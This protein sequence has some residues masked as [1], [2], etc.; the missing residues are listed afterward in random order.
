MLFCQFHDVASGVGVARMN[1]ETVAWLSGVIADMTAM[2]HELRK[3]VFAINEGEGQLLINTL[4]WARNEWVALPDGKEIYAEIPADGVCPAD[5][6]LPQPE[7]ASA[8]VQDGLIHLENRYLQL[9]IDQG[10]AIVSLV[11]KENSA[12]LIAPGQ[13][14]NDWRLYQNVEAVYD[15]WEMSLDWAQGFLPEA[16]TAKAELTEASPARCVVTVTRTFGSSSAKQQII[17]RAASRRVDFTSHI[18]WKE[19]HRL[20]K[21]HFASNILTDEALHEI[22]FGY[23]K[24]PCHDSHAF[25]ADRYEVSN[26]HWSALCEENRGF[27]LLNESS[28]GLSTDRGEMALSLLRAPLVPDDTCDVGEHDIA[29]ALYPFATGFSASGVTKEGY[30][31]NA[32]V[33][34]LQGTCPAASGFRCDSGSIILETV[35]PADDGNGVILRLYEGLRMQGTATVHA[36]IP[37]KWYICDMPEATQG[38]FLCE[39]DAASIRLAPF[40]I[41]TLRF[42]PD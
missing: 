35:K 7:D 14:M 13:K 36:P 31:F 8:W 39:G 10:G 6:S 1:E 32:S 23:V 38:E 37:G 15:A 2:N 34:V 19:R 40:K 41:M 16:I 22:Q 3:A 24:R 29:Y 4:P 20:L 21:A 5:A 17:L 33:E 27:A 28:C 11:D 9:A 26:Q 12:P 25:A 30:A 18:D 42:I